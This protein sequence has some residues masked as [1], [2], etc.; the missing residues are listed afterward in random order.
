M[1]RHICHFGK[2]ILNLSKINVTS[3]TLI[4]LFQGLS[5]P[6]NNF[7]KVISFKSNHLTW[8]SSTT[9]RF[10]YF[11]QQNDNCGQMSQ[12]AEQP[13]EIHLELFTAFKVTPKVV[14]N[15]VHFIKK[16]PRWQGHRLKK[17]NLTRS[18]F[19]LQIHC[20]VLTWNK[21]ICRFIPSAEKILSPKCVQ[22]CQALFFLY[23]KSLLG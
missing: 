6:N 16:W 10:P 9:S 22:K 14:L 23:Y 21:M 11:E 15:R 3:Q 19:Q 1:S 2:A 12:I 7:L 17:S 13:K 18:K 8:N 5:T 4:V 20:P